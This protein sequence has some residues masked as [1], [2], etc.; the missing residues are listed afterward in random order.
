MEQFGELL[1]KYIAEQNVSVSRAAAVC[2]MNRGG[3]YDVFNG[4]RK[5]KQ[6]ELFALLKSGS[7]GEAQEKK[8]RAAFF[9]S[10]YGKEKF[11]RIMFLLESISK[12]L[13]TNSDMFPS[14]EIDP[15]SEINVIS[16]LS[17]ISAAIEKIFKDAADSN[18]NE[19]ITN[20]SFRLIDIDN[21]FYS[22]TKQFAGR[23]RFRHFVTVD[24]GESTANIR[25]SFASIKYVSSG[26]HPLFGKGGSY[27]C[28]ERLPYP[29]YVLSAQHLFLFDSK[30]TRGLFVKDKSAAAAARLKIGEMTA[31]FKTMT[32]R[33]ESFIDLRNAYVPSVQT[34]RAKIIEGGVCFGIAADDEIINESVRM[35]LPCRDA[36]I[37]IYRQ[38][39][40]EYYSGADGLMAV[41]LFFTT[42]GI[43]D[44][45]E[46]GILYDLSNEFVEPLPAE[47]RLRVLEKYLDILNDKT[48]H[49]INII[50]G[51]RLFVD[52]KLLLESQPGSGALIMTALNE[53]TSFWGNE[54]VYLCEPA[55]L[56][57][58]EDMFDYIE[59]H[60]G[61][62]L[63]KQESISFMTQLINSLK[64]QIQGG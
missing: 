15:S 54:I 31:S 44:F 19:I 26:L 50:D 36:M 41:E 28:C 39:L 51:S 40:S 2:G 34:G 61:L 3:L 33:T 42:A 43:Q 63:S 11:E 7:F 29:Y 23:V 12:A 22:L 56:Q 60:S 27:D 4:K 32:K 57:D 58:V 62:L 14:G 45:A 18:D 48:R 38:Y 53:K 49:T 24:S 35:D 1:R 6:S 46:N 10:F 37:Q 20:F 16:G 52:K 13:Q 9:S 5:M 8:L 30:G 59:N 17:S 64:A 21:L 47:T 25:S 55:I